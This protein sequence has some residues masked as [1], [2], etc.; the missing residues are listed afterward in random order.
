MTAHQSNAVEVGQAAPAFD[1]LD[2]HGEPISLAS[3]AGSPVLLYFYPKAMTPGCTQQSCLLRDVA[4]QIGDARIV[5]ISPDVPEKLGRFDQKYTLGFTLLSDPDHAVAEAYGAWGQK[6][7]YGKVYDGIIR[8]AFL[9]D[10]A[11]TVAAAFPKIS[12]KDTPNKLL[13]ELQE[14]SG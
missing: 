5:G 3:L 9:V 14:L 8:S 4:D 1:L 10:R 13:A 11:G 12:P 7:L 6:K 2:Q